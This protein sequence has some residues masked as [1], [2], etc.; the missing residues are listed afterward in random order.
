LIDTRPSG[1]SALLLFLSASLAGF[2]LG[3]AG[4]AAGLPD[5]VPGALPMPGSL[6]P[7]PGAVLAHDAPATAP[8]PALFGTP[9]PV[10]VA[11]PTPEPEPEWPEEVVYDP[12]D[13]V[14]RGL[15]VDNDGGMAM[16][17][18]D[19]GLQVVRPGDILPGGEEV[20]EIHD[21]GVDIEAFGEVYFIE[22]DDAAQS[23]ELYNSV[24]PDIGDAPSF[25]ASP[26]ITGVIGR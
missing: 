9:P 5:H 10:I 19:E 6:G 26:Y 17:D 8:W 3:L 15:I 1:A 25:P 13:Y 18:T 4:L 7:V 12:P 24:E 16:L 14:L 22:F 2:G 21:F 23:D 11:E 20:I